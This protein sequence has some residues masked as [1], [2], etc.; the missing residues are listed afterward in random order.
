[1]EEI[2]RYQNQNILVKAF[3]N[4]AHR[5]AYIAWGLLW[6]TFVLFETWS[7]EDVSDLWCLYMGLSEM[8]MR[9]YYTHEEVLAMIE[10]KDE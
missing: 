10:E 5:P 1:M 7:F 3:R 6:C 8:K 9:L 2:N 4:F